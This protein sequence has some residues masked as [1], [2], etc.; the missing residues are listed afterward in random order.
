MTEDELQEKVSGLLS[1][2]QGFSPSMLKG[3]FGNVKA[4]C[5][6]CLYPEG[7]RYV[8]DCYERG[9]RFQHRTTCDEDEA[10]FWVLYDVVSELA[11]HYEWQH[12]KPLEDSRRQA[13]AKISEMFSFIGA[14]YEEM[15]QAKIN[16]ILSTAPYDDE[17]HKIL[18]LAQG[19]EEIVNELRDLPKTFSI[20]GKYAVRC[21]QG[22]Y[23]R[24]PIGG[25]ENPLQSVTKMRKS[26][27]AICKELQSRPPSG[28][29]QDFEC[30]AAE[31]EKI[32]ASI[33]TK[34]W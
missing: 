23:Y 2:I 4:E 32:Y 3:R 18:Y 5:I 30:K 28:P 22:R 13:F 25:M 15:W 34:D 1:K 10:L 14:P 9:Q 16:A 29:R 6:P 27:L 24:E 31:F 7:D 19:Y 21:I 8:M 26:I 17:I 33:Y 20:Q 12:R 11:F